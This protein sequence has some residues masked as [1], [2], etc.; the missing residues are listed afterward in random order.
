V[1]IDK[2]NIKKLVIDKKWEKTLSKG[3]IGGSK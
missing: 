3:D 2:K 1:G